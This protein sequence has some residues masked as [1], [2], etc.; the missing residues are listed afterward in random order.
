MAS[1][2]KERFKLHVLTIS[3][4]LKVFLSSIC[5]PRV[6]FFFYLFICNWASTRTKFSCL[7]WD[8]LPLNKAALAWKPRTRGTAKE[9]K[10]IFETKWHTKNNISRFGEIRP[11]HN[12]WFE[13]TVQKMR[14]G[15]L[16][17][18]L[19]CQF[20]NPHRR[21]TLTLLQSFCRAGASRQALNRTFRTRSRAVSITACQLLNFPELS[22]SCD[23]SSVYLGERTRIISNAICNS[24]QTFL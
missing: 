3:K 23:L 7:L 21:Q 2:Q 24:L 9:I 18:V 12:V 5:L 14:A 1:L 19:L 8:G 17:I 22:D 20:L 15:T 13:M 10:K 11:C 6:L 4:T 16:C